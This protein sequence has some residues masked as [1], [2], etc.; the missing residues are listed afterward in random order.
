MLAALDLATG[1]L[2][3]RIR[4]RKRWREVLAFLKLLR[5]RYEGRLYVVLDNFSPH[6][7]REV[8]DWCDDHEGSWCSPRPTPRG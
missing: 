8:T 1:T 7:K 3:Y 5:Q 2:T 4:H 6:R